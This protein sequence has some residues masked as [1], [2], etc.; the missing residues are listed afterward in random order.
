[1]AAPSSVKPFSP[2]ETQTILHHLQQPAVFKNMTCGWPVLRWT[3]EH[4]SGCLG[5]KLIRFRLGRK[6]EKNTPLFETQCSYVEAKLAHFLSWTQDQPGTDVG[7]FSEYPKSEYWAYA[8]YKY[9]ALLF[10]D[11]PSMFE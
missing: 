3:A 9:I 6:E 7:P 11:Q 1:M 8:D 2:E 5:N 4:L 10:Q